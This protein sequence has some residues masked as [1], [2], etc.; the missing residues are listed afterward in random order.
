MLKST[1]LRVRTAARPVVRPW[2][3]IRVFLTPKSFV[4]FRRNQVGHHSKAC[5]MEYLIQPRGSVACGSEDF[6]TWSL[7]V[8]G[9]FARVIGVS[10]PGA[11]MASRPDG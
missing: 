1:P 6:P 2:D 5:T 8:G 7:L 11:Q 10:L 9:T 3:E 4:P